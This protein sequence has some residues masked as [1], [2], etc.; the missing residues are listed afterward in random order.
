VVPLQQPFG[1]EAALHPHEPEM[2]CCPA[3]HAAQLAP[4]VP[5]EPF[6]CEVAGSHVPLDVQ[7]PLGHDVALQTHC[8]LVLHA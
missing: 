8:P 3:P 1:H 4:P 6:D 2:H 5:Q 7:Q